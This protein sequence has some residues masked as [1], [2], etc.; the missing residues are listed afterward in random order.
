MTV[1]AKPRKWYTMKCQHEGVHGPDSEHGAVQRCYEETVMI[2]A[3]NSPE[4]AA[5][6]GALS[7]LDD[8]I[9]P[10]TLRIIREMFRLE[11]EEGTLNDPDIDPEDD[12]GRSRPWDPE[13]VEG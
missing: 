2:R 8:A 7:A 4:G 11:E 3:E 13:G 10:Y 9:G 12:Y 5:L 6:R 1:A